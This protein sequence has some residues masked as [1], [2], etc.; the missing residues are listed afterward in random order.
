VSMA[1]HSLLAC[2]SALCSLTTP[3]AL[4]AFTRRVALF[5]D[6]LG[7]VAQRMDDLVLADVLESVDAERRTVD[8]RHRMACR[9]FFAQHMTFGTPPVTAL[10][11]M[12][13]SRSAKKY[14]KKR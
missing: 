5:R 10:A 8:N 12:Y 6:L 4:R 2:S 11:D 1:S 7:L 13:S 9:R 3:G 14:R